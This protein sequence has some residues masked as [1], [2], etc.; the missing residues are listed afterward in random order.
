MRSLLRSG[1]NVGGIGARGYLLQEE[2]RKAV[3]VIR[4]PLGRQN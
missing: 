3:G 2:G 4:V 1:H